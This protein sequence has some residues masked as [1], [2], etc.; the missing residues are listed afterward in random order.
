VTEPTIDTQSIEDAIKEKLAPVQAF[1]RLSTSLAERNRV[2]MQAVDRSAD[3]E[4]LAIEAFIDQ[5][6]HMRIQQVR[7]AYTP[8]ARDAHVRAM[9][10]DWLNTIT[11]DNGHT[12]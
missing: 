3:R 11:N 5:A 2:A 6:L 12:L 4:R 10:L 7:G 8:G 9:L 1:P